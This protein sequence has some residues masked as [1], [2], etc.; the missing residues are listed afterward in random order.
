LFIRYPKPHSVLNDLAG[1]K[2]AAFTDWKVTVIKA[3]TA[4]VKPATANIHH[5]I[6]RNP[7]N[8]VYDSK[9]SRRYPRLEKALG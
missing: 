7:L 6:D 3:I 8:S 2:E 5:S 9:K 4:A 1:F